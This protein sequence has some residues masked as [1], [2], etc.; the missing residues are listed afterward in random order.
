MVF[1]V[2]PTIFVENGPAM[3]VEENVVV[4]SDGAELL[5]KRQDELFLIGQKK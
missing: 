5:S 1:T 3:L 4:K 2:E